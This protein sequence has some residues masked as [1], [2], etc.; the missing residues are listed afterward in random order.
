[1]GVAGAA[2]SNV[3]SQVIGSVLGLWILFTGR[4]RIKMAL[5]DFRVDPKL[6]WRMLKIGI[7]ALVMNLQRN[8]GNLVLTWL[9]A[10]FGTV[11]IAAHSIAARVEMFIFMPAMG[12]GSGAGVLVGQNL[13]ARQ[14]DRAEKSAWRAVMVAEIFFSVCGIALLIWANSIMKVF[15]DD[16]ELIAMGATFLRIAVV[17]YIAMALATVLQNAIASAGDTLPNMII[18]IV[19][20]WAVQLPLAFLLARMTDL[21]VYGIRWGIVSATIALTLATLV[22]FRM[23]RWKRKR[24]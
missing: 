17:S 7:P 3:I 15:S 12:L 6:I 14:P 20:I 22:Y 23:G 11:A 5:S 19:S 9:I 10:P 8:I 4:T 24:V 18:S 16:P 1:M 21:G 2:L 13:G